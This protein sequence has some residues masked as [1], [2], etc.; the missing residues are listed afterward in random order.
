MGG[1][2]ATG[3]L[4]ARLFQGDISGMIVWQPDFRFVWSPRN[5]NV[6]RRGLEAWGELAPG[7]GLRL[8]GSYTLAA[9]TYDRPGDPEPVQVAYRPRHTAQLDGAWEHD[10]WRAG[11]VALFTGTRYPAPARLNALDPF[12]TFRLDLGR[13]WRLGGIDLTTNLQVDRLFDEKDTLIFGFPEAGR[14][15][16]LEARIQ[17][18]G[19]S[20]QHSGFRIRDSGRGGR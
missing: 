1:R 19:F 16:R 10:G 3:A 8:A 5:T 17:D 7:G 4:G 15:F 14:R 2:A 20:I 12:W 18:S 11:V 6:K 13:E 9:V